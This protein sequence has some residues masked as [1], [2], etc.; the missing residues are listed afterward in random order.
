VLPNLQR[1]LASLARCGVPN[2]KRNRLFNLMAPIPWLM[3]VLS[4]NFTVFISLAPP[5][6]T[7]LSVLLLSYTCG[8]LPMFFIAITWLMLSHRKIFTN[9]WGWITPVIC[10]AVSSL[11]VS[12][13]TISFL[14]NTLV[15]L[16]NWAIGVATA[17][18]LWQRDLGL[19]LLGW[20]SI[21]Y[22]WTLMLA[23]RYQ[24][25]LIELWIQSLNNFNGSSPLWWLNL[26][27]V[28]AWVV[29][30]SLLSVIGHTVRLL[31]REL[32]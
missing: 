20:V 16:S 19:K 10:L 6:S 2:V 3:L 13:P 14:L 27:C 12:Q 25:N 32:H 8:I 28:A 15:L 21:A 7:D 5:D 23:W 31:W 22:I 18:L 29:P 4:L 11:S 1:P 30:I 9:G 26:W 24:G 17:I